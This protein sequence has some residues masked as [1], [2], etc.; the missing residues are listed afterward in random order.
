[1][2]TLNDLLDIA[3]TMEKNGEKIYLN[4]MGQVKSEQLKSLLKWMAKEETHH[5]KWFSSLKKQSLDNSEDLE[6][7][8]PDI[9]RE[10]MGEKSLSLDEVDFSRIKTTGQMLA[11]FAEFESDT[12]LFYEFLEPFI[13]DADSLAGL[14]KIITEENVHKEKLALMFQSVEDGG[15]REAVNLQF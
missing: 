10:M 9:I 6:T 4:A 14:K 12:I 3:V 7:M 2:F 5:A 13:D 1:M 11:V 8:L 15:A